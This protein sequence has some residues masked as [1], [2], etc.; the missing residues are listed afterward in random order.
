MLKY[1]AQ[2][3]TNNGEIF[4]LIVVVERNSSSVH[5]MGDS[6]LLIY[7]VFPKVYYLY[8]GVSSVYEPQIKDCFYR[9]CLDN[10]ANQRAWI[11]T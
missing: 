4:F 2:S 9:F 6:N 1:G 5:V 7:C 11:T 3:G 8:Y 10:N